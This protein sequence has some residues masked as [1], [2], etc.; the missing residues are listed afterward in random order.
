M[1]GCTGA[2]IG[3]GAIMVAE[4]VA[5][6]D[7]WRD[8][9]IDEAR[10]LGRRVQRLAD[11]VFD[12]PVANYRARL[13]ESLRI[14]GVLEDASVRPPLLGARRGRVPPPGGDARGS[15]AAEGR[16]GVS[17]RRADVLIVGAG[18]SGGVVA[19]RLAAA[20]LRRGL[21]RAGRLARARR[22]PGAATGVRAAGAQAVG[23]QP[24]RPRLAGGLP[25][26]RGRLRH[27]DADVQRRRR[28]PDPVRRR[29]VAA[30]SVGLLRAHAGRRG[31]RL[32]D[33][34]RGPAALLRADRRRVRRLRARRRPRL[35]GA[36]RA[37]LPAAADRRRRAEGR[38]RAH[39]ARLALVAGHQLGAVGPRA[40]TPAPARSG[41]AACGAVPRARRRAPTTPTGSRRSPTAP[42]SSPA[43]ASAAC[44]SAA[45]GWPPAS[46]T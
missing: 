44:W 40:R 3:F 10:E 22:V 35:P 43:R 30:A 24:E 17:A 16:R 12:A 32:A 6:I 25:G 27:R 46:S 19:R 7:A 9:R 28:Q 15:R 31:R 4:Q 2:L 42:S 41:A 36:V 13:K 39:P 33:Q 5:M 37:A 8:G 38:A 34:L 18:A 20:G 23:P 21:P 14:L 11:V 29:L 1:L 26:Q 45:T